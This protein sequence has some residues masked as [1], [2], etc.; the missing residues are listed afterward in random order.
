MSILQELAK[1]DYGIVQPL[2]TS[3]PKHKKA[4]L[5]VSLSCIQTWL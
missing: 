3:F 4:I 5:V 1:F 2:Q